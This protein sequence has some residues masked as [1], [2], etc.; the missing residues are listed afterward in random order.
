MSVVWVW[1][2]VESAMHEIL[3][4]AFMYLAALCFIAFA[5]ISTRCVFVRS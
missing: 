4:V 1:E 5:L 2:I 3:S